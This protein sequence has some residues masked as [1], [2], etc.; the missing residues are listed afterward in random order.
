MTSWVTYAN[1]GVTRNQPLSAELVQ[2]LAF[3]P[4]LGLRAEV[5]SG[6]QHNAEDA[7]HHGT[8][9]VGSTRHDD[10]G[11]GDMHLYMGDTRLSHRNPEHIPILQDVV[12][13]AR[14][15]GI[16]GIGM[17]DGYMGDHGIHIGYGAPAVWGAGGSS[18][19][20]PGWLSEAYNGAPAGARQPGNT[21]APMVQGQQAGPDE[22]NALRN[23]AM[24]Q[25]S[26]TPN[27]LDASAFMRPMT[28]PQMMPIPGT[29]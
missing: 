7:A 20:A 17:G 25:Q 12:R 14:A 21:F 10:G 9:R 16:T 8:G 4:E 5:Y 2:A 1:Q 13:R 22:N 29:Y 18:A 26:Q 27:L 24:F 23:F 15:A 11:A 6:G 3:L 28:T 19:N